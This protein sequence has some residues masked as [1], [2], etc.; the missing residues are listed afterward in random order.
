MILGFGKCRQ[1]AL[2][3]EP[4]DWWDIGN[5]GSS[6][7]RTFPKALGAFRKIVELRGQSLRVRPFAELK[8]LA[9][10]PV[11]R[12]TVESR[13][14]TIAVSTFPMPS[15]GL[16]IVIQGFLA[17]RFFPGKSVAL[18]GFYKYPDETIAPMSP[19]EF[20]DFD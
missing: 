20:W 16:Q 7:V 10:Q 6:R 12:I 1:L 8:E 4:G 5:S 9:R 18:D 13:P 14:A 19:E 3:A 15:G 11:E 2:L 17:H